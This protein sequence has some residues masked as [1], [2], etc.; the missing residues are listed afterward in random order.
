M[1]LDPQ[2]VTLTGGMQLGGPAAGGLI[3]GIC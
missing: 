3:G 1:G 2:F